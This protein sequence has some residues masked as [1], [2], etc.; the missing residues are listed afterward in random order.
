[1]VGRAVLRASIDRSTACWT[2]RA[3]SSA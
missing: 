3:N 1:M 2:S